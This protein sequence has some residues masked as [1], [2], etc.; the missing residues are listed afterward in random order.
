MRVFGLLSLFLSLPLFAASEFTTQIHDIDY[1]QKEG[2]EVLVF[3]KSGHVAK[4][5]HSHGLLNQ[6]FMSSKM[7]DK[8]FKIKLDDERFITDLDLVK[9]PIDETRKFKSM[10]EAPMSYIPTTIASMDI[11]KKYHREARYNPKESQCFNR[12]QVWSYEWWRK[13]SLKS[14]KILIYFTRTYIRRY[15]FE[16]WFHIAPYVHVMENGKVVERVM[17]I[18]Y[19]SGPRE[20]QK[21]ANIF[22]RNDA[23]CP[24]ITKYSDYADYPYTG[25]CYFQRTHMYTYQPADL[26]MYEAWGY[27][28]DNWI[29]KEVQ[30]A[31]EEAF[32]ESL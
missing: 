5:R 1:G 12:A 24:V 19:T 15:N 8:W 9:A 18:K 10:F 29:M 25:E 27:Q 3:L 26:Q 28:K 20:F 23:P 30:W 16:W 21:W 13:H 11:A 32:D 14:M 6:D 22:L 4:L 2:D 7:K 31:Y 17:D